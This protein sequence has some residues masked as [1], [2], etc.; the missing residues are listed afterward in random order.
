MNLHAIKSKGTL[1]D[2]LILRRGEYCDDRCR[3]RTNRQ[4][5]NPAWH[6]ECL[7]TIWGEPVWYCTCQDCGRNDRGATHTFYYFRYSEGS[8]AGSTLCRD[9]AN[10]VHH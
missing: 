9:C 2:L 8:Y 4:E 7:Q 3:Y 10:G 6:H 1:T 5:I